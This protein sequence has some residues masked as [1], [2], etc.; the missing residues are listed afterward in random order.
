MKVGNEANIPLIASDTDSVPRGAIAALGLNYFNLGEQTGT[1][2]TRILKGEK[3]GTIAYET[4]KNLALH[5]NKKAAAEQGVT[6]S[7]D[8]VKS[9]AKVIE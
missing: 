7:D 8:L 2:V 4:S 5:I 9:A 1:V 6:L 3:P